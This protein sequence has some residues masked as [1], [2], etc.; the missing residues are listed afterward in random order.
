MI[1]HAT[2]RAGMSYAETSSIMTLNSSVQDSL[3]KRN[4]AICSNGQMRTPTVFTRIWQASFH[5][6]FAK[7]LRGHFIVFQY[8]CVDVERMCDNIYIHIQYTCIL[9][10]GETLYTGQFIVINGDGHYFIV[11]GF[12]KGW[13][14]PCDT[15]G[16]S[17][18]ATLL[19]P[20]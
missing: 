8:G 11:G 19:F 3:L 17:S 10:E 16:A 5:V 6:S 1:T 18:F 15:A 12:F 9:T 13:T 20:V 4:T 14:F 2:H 7:L